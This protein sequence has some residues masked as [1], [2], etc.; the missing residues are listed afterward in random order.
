MEAGDDGDFVVRRPED[1]AVG[2]PPKSRA[3]N[4]LEL[5]G[6]LLRVDRDPADLEI[7]LLPEA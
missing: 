4:V 1:Q 5:R 6:K 7:E 2:E 3:L